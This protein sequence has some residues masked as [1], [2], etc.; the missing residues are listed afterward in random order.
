MLGWTVILFLSLSRQVDA[1]ILIL[2]PCVY[3]LSVYGLCAPF[4]SVPQDVSPI[5]L[6]R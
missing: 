2:L 3:G 5:C 1:Q 4:V 6:T